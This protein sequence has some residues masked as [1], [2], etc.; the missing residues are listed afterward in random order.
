M[1]KLSAEKVA[2]M[3]P[4]VRV[5]YKA[6]LRRVQRNRKIAAVISIVAVISV[7]I[8]ALS[9]TVFFNITDIRVAKAGKAY[10]AEEIISAS[11]LNIGENMIRTDFNAVSAR[12]EKNL[13][14]ILDAQISKSL[15]GKITITV[16]DDKASMIYEMENGKFAL[17]DAD[18]KVLEIIDKAPENNK[19]TVLKTQNE[20]NSSVGEIISFSS[21]E[22]SGLYNTIKSTM[23][24]AGLKD[25]TKIDISEPTD[26]YLEYQNRFRLHVGTVTQLEEKLKSAVETIALEDESN[27]GGIGEINLTI[28]KKTY[29]KPLETLDETTTEQ[30]ETPKTQEEAT[31]A[32]TENE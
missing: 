14:Y 4:E 6:K 5:K 10:K 30:E 16:T 17:T 22:E 23:N 18:G 2:R 25:I 31:D 29:V 13:P 26:I 24:T 8:A 20:V 21:E 12:I 7:I 32:S 15:S 27:P 1:K 11:G 3:T 19:F 28:I 9:V